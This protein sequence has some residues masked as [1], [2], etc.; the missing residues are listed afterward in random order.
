M[1]GS[2]YHPSPL[3][4]VTHLNVN[5]LVIYYKSVFWVMH[6]GPEFLQIIAL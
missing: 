3:H 4:L 2:T 6:L 1:F 5:E